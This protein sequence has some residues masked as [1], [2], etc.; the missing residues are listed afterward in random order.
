MALRLSAATTEY[1]R[2]PVSA[3]ENGSVV[4]PTTDAVQMAFVAADA[5]P[6]NTDWKTAS[7]ETDGS[8]YYA[9]CL[10]GPSGD[11]TPAVGSY[12]VWVKLTDNPEIPVR[13]AGRLVIF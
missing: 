3:K 2:I 7:W 10:V 5:A 6:G 13:R 9:R 8:T 12:H 1:V 11:A 4:N